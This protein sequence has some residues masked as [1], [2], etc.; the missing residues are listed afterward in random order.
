MKQINNNAIYKIL[1]PSSNNVV[2]V[3]N[4]NDVDKTYLHFW[5]KIDY[6]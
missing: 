1:V 3:C 2:D 6:N 4:W 5:E